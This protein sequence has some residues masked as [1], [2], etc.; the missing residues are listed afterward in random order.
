MRLI[1]PR[2]IHRPVS[3][4]GLPAIGGESLLPATGVFVLHRPDEAAVDV[5]A[6]ER[7]IGVK[8]AA[9][10]AQILRFHEFIELLTSHAK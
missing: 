9:P 1:F 4:P 8:Q 7:F 5:S 2:E 6:L 3:L 10:V